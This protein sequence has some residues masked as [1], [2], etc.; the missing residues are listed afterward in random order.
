MNGVQLWRK[1]EDRAE[2]P[3]LGVDSI[4]A[5][6]NLVKEAAATCIGYQYQPK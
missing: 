3:G 2:D 4:W 6:E 1:L 5:W